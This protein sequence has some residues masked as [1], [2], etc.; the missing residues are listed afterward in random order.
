[1]ARPTFCRVGIFNLYTRGMGMRR[2]ITSVE[3]LKPALAYQNGL[4]LMQWPATERSKARTTGVHWKMVAMVVAMQKLPTQASMKVQA[5]RN[6]R[7]PSKI[8]RYSSKMAALV[9]LMLSL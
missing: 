6:Q 9:E 7:T 4:L 5:H 2:I 1:M 8:R 3:M